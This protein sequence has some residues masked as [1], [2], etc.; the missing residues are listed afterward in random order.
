MLALQIKSESVGMRK[1]SFSH[2]LNVHTN[3][4]GNKV[5]MKDP[6]N[7][8]RLTDLSFIYQHAFALFLAIF[9]AVVAHVEKIQNK[10]LKGFHIVVFFYDVIVSSFVG[11]LTLYACLHFSV[12]MEATGVLVGVFAHQGTRG[13]ALLTNA[14]F[15]R[16]GV[17]N[18]SK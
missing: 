3:F 14:V 18:E 5:P 7:W 2:T 13:L 11:V 16:F 15:K 9:A 4:K 17:K 10:T 8:E 6:N 12:S 1:G